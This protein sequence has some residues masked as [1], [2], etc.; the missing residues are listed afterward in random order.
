M[1]A[2][3]SGRLH[4]RSTPIVAKLKE[5]SAHFNG[6]LKDRQTQKR[7]ANPATTLKHYQKSLS[8]EQQASVEALDASYKDPR[9]N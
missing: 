8:E 4:S 7:H 3:V 1:P 2:S 6:E 5:T 9:V